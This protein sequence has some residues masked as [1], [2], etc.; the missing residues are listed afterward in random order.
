MYEYYVC[1]P[2]LIWSDASAE[3]GNHSGLTDCHLMEQMQKFMSQNPYLLRFKHCFVLNR[4]QMT[5]ATLTPRCYEAATGELMGVLLISFSVKRL[6]G[7]N[8]YAIAESVRSLIHFK[9]NGWY[10]RKSQLEPGSTTYIPVN[11]ILIPVI[12]R[13]ADL[14][15]SHGNV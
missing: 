10:W 15:T 4:R 11:K 8:S 13:A 6:T 7:S 12:E 14:C 9:T 2:Q 1:T 3:L 5:T